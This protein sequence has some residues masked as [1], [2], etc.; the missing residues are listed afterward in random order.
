MNNVIISILTMGIMGAFFAYG[1]S[2]ALK[3]FK[4]EEDPRIDQVEAALPGANCGACGYP[5]CR[6]LAEAIAKGEVEPGSC[7]VGGS[8]SAREVARI[9]GKE[10]TQ[11]ERKVAV[12]LCRG[13]DEAAARKAD[14]RGVKTC[15]AASLVQ[16]GDKFCSYGCLGYED[17]VRACNFDAL[18]MGPEGLPMVDREKCTACGLC[19]KA[20]PKNLIELHPESR[21]FFVFCKSLDIPKTSRT[22][23]KNA[24]TGCMICTKG[25]KNNEIVVTDNL[26]RINSLD[27][28]GS[29]EA[30]QWVAKCPTKAIGFLEKKQKN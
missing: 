19:V 13:T 22:N 6:A 20:C 5:G 1:L 15:Y 9:M 21:T 11:T 8:E 7:P 10:A 29:E 27:I 3:K 2:I 16:S 4:I 24:C 28:L 17:C 18:H 26:S 30:M 25:A 12:L 14:Y 23:C